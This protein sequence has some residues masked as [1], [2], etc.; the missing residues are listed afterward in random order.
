MWRAGAHALGAYQPDD[1]PQIS[2]SRDFLTLANDEQ[3]DYFAARY[4][5]GMVDE[6]E[7]GP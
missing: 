6:M 3:L 2:V 1:E 4:T 5:R 7:Q